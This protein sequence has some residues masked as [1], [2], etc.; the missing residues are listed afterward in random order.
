MPITVLGCTEKP[1]M[2]VPVRGW[3]NIRDQGSGIR[4]QGSGIRDQK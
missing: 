2:S 3:R 1:V 4:D